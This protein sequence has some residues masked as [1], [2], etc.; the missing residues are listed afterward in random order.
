MQ[1]TDEEEKE[2]LWYLNEWL[3][4]WNNK[5]IHENWMYPFGTEPNYKTAKQISDYLAEEMS[6][7][8]L[9]VL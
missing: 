5:F 6:E 8:A 3:E 7:A 4:L 2:M 9:K 1:L